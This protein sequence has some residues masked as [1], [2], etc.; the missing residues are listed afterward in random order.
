MKKHTSI[1][2]YAANGFTLIEIM[3]VISIIAVL[4]A[5]IYSSVGA[6]KVNAQDAK[7]SGDINSLNTALA[8]YANDHG[9]HVPTAQNSSCV[10][11]NDN[12]SWVCNSAS[13]EGF[14]IAL[15]PLVA[16]HYISAIP[17][18]PVNSDGQAYWYATGPDLY[19]DP[20]DP[21]HGES[22]AG[23]VRYVSASQ[24]QSDGGTP[25]VYGYNVGIPDYVNYSPSGYPLVDQTAVS[26]GGSLQAPIIDAGAV[27]V[28]NSSNNVVIT[29]SPV[30]GATSYTIYYQGFKSNMYLANTSNTTYTD[31]THTYSQATCY[32]ATASDSSGNV[33]SMSDQSCATMFTGGPVQGALPPSTVNA[34]YSVQNIVIY[35]PMITVSWTPG[36]ANGNTIRGYNIY[37]ASTNTLLGTVSAS[38]S[39]DNNGMYDYSPTPPSQLY[40]WPSG[41]YS[42]YVTTLFAQYGE[43]GQSPTASV[44]IPPKSGDSDGQ[45]QPNNDQ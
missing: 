39:L 8:E 15:Q 42:F 43:S 2:K 11:G 23:S 19:P 36:Q 16:G 41:T 24:T 12:V 30:A 13:P 27:S 45:Q 20:N 6:A 28:N 25:I 26:E 33:S 1:K 10:L 17:Q 35:N 40:G 29:I 4:T 14:N 9:G 44:S 31:L 37:D 21:N 18:D 7:R 3:V 38:E 5:V 22:D 32:T 34:S